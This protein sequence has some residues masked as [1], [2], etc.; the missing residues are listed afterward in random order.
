[1]QKR[2]AFILL[3]LLFSSSALT[4]QRGFK[5]VS[6]PE[7]IEIDLYKGS[8]ALVVGNG[9]YT[10]GW[11]PLPGA[12]KDA[13]DV[14]GFLRKNGFEVA[15]LKNAK[16]EEFLTSLRDFTY[17]YSQDEDNQ[18]FIYYAGHGYTRALT[19]GEE[20]GYLVMVDAPVPEKDPRG[21]DDKSID[22]QTIITEAKK[23]K[24]KHV[25]F[26]FDSCF[27]GT[28]LNLRE[29][30]MPKAISEAVKYPVRQFITAGRADEPVPDRSVFK[31]LFI[32][33]L[34]GK[35]EEPIKDGYLTGE[36]LGLYLKN[37]VP[38]YNK[39][40]HPQ[41]GKIRDPNLDQGDF[42][43]VLEKAK[44]VE[45]IETQLPPK[46]PETAGLD[47]T[48]IK[49]AEEERA[50]IEAQWQAWQGKMRS[51]FNELEKMER[52]TDLGSEQK[53]ALWQKYL[54][55]YNADNP[56]SSED[57]QMRQ[58]A[59]QRI[60]EL[61]KVV[62]SI[63]ARVS[64]RSFAQ[65]LSE[66]EVG[67]MLKRHNFFSEKFLDVNK[68]FYN[69]SG[70]FANNYQSRVIN[71]DKV[72][73]DHATGLMWHQSGSENIISYDEVKQWI[74]DLNNRGYAGYHDWRLPTLEE[75]ASL[76]ESTKM[77]SNLYIDPKF[78][79]KQDSWIWTSD[80][81]SGAS[82][83]DWGVHFSLGGVHW[84]ARVNPVGGYG[85]V[86]PVRSGKELAKVDISAGARVSLRSS[87][88]SLNETEVGAMLRQYNFFSK[89]YNRNKDFC[90]P[91]GDFK[92]NFESSVINGDK[93]V[94]DYATS[95]MWHQSGSDNTMTYAQAK[96]WIADLNNRGYA[97]YRDWYL[98]TLEEGASLLE[99]TQM[100]GDL[101]IDPKFSAS[102]GFIWTS[103]MLSSSSRWA[104]VVNFVYGSVSSDNVDTKGYRVR[105]VRS[106]Q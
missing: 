51:D 40:Q 88:Q 72:V 33:I 38:E 4:Q 98:P 44:L 26:M 103:D 19:T 17:K 9:K 1:V 23:M 13:E 34:E 97:G 68:S 87:G 84:Y 60:K 28:V 76:L 99:R 77:N 69:P 78:S 50:K 66:E 74:A 93:V 71:G 102:H 63:G 64:L 2:L 55:T 57:E 16:R 21:F 25:L 106:G 90:N 54:D 31:Q 30:M 80:A 70:D 89:Q 8:Y 43:F 35:V 59:A 86:R 83:C 79:K 95:L 7:G 104:W 105:P 6:T 5:R 53:K 48:S 100:N 36:E 20:L 10:A 39:F 101:Y 45:A 65:S 37:K 94:L 91:E 47:L 27:S 62:L 3:I 82:G 75:A 67:A 73:L 92:N 12:E 32:N 42:V 46:P 81:V 22:M 24:A 85:Y 15:L 41:Y 14:A 58:R 52:S 61:S 49:K 11:D 29:R 96:Q 56:F 18:V